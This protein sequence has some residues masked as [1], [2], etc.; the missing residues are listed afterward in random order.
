MNKPTDAHM[1]HTPG[2]W[3]IDLH[4]EYKAVVY[5]QDGR[6]KRI[7]IADVFGSP[8]A[9]QENNTRLIATA[10]ILLEACSAVLAMIQSHQI[11]DKDAREVLERAIRSTR[12]VNDEE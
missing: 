3:K 11:Y 6:A 12:P 5:K 8:R 9:E 10:P 7:I 4:S 1:N 2:P